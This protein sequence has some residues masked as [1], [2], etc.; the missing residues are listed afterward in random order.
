MKEQKLKMTNLKIK[1]DRE[2]KIII[3]SFTSWVM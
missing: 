1:N 2:T 3:V